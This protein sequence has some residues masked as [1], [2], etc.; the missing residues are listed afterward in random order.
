MIPEDGSYIIVDH[1]FANA[2]QGAIGL[3]S[4]AMKADVKEMEH[5]NLPA[6]ATPTKPEAAQGKLNFE[7]KCLACH[8]VGQGKKLGP[9]M[10]G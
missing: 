1:H 6:S 7:S 5:H 3:I 2:S 9:D 4:T 8:S 10:V